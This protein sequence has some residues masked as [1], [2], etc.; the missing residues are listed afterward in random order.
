MSGNGMDGRGELGLGWR[1]EFGP[2]A[3]SLGL[4]RFVWSW[5]ATRV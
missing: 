1:D 3:A 5:Q 2:G 4:S